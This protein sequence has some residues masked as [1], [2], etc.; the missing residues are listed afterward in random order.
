MARETFQ[1]QLQEVQDQ[2]LALGR[3]VNAAVAR[4]TQAL[5]TRDPALAQAVLAAD[6]VINE[7]RFRIEEQALLLLATQAPVAGDLRRLAA[8]LSIVTDLERMGDH[9]AGNARLAL[10]LGNRP[11]LHA[12][13]DISRM[14][15]ICQEM[16]QAALAAYV[17]ADALAAYRVTLRDDEVDQLYDQ[18]YR[19]L[20]T[21]M[22]ADPATI[23]P[24]THLLAVGHNLERIADRVTNICE[25]VAFL[26]TG[27]MTEIPSAAPPAPPAPPAP[28]QHARRSARPAD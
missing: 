20:L 26:V 7:A 24:A 14:A 3:L 28:A 2:V 4:S 6:T 12:L 15:V 5:Q 10:L 13:I 21:Y 8:A 17:A 1:Q 27:H 19:I 18:S 11:P 22:L 16:L 9:A 23:S 25:R